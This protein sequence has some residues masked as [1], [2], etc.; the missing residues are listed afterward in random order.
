MTNEIPKNASE[1]LYTCFMYSIFWSALI[2][3]FAGMYSMNDFVTFLVCWF[4]LGIAFAV[5]SLSNKFDIYTICFSF[6]F[7]GLMLYIIWIFHIIKLIELLDKTVGE[8]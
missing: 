6:L 2:L 5:V 1:D 8:Y 3:I 7:S 4:I